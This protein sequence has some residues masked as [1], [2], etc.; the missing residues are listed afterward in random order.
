MKCILSNIFDITSGLAYIDGMTALSPSADE[1]LSF[2]EK[3]A[4]AC[5]AATAAVYLPYFGYVSRLFER[6]E[7][8][9]DAILAAFVGAV[10][11][12]GF[13]NVVLHVASLRKSAVP[14]KP[15]K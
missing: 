11:L 12:H 6:D 5:L 4:W 15:P 1:T 10:A 2:R 8:R 13:F 3:S 7:L 14:P 9:F